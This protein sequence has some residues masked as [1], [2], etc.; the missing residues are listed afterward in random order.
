MNEELIQIKEGNLKLKEEN[1]ELL[2]SIEYLKKIIDGLL[3]KFILF[4]D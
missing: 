2:S 3:D 4:K 1:S